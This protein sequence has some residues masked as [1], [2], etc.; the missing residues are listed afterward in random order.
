MEVSSE[1]PE[2]Q[3]LGKKLRDKRRQLGYTQADIADLCG[4]TDRTLREVE[5]GSGKAKMETW[6]KLGQVLGFDL[7]LLQKPMRFTPPA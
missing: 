1:I 5:A 6:F 7:T 3:A 4:I 2:L